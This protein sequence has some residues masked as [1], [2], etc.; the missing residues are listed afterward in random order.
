MSDSMGTSD[1]EN[2]M[3]ALVFQCAGCKLIVGDSYCMHSTNEAMKSI[4]LTA[5]SNIRR[6]HDIYTSK[7]GLDVGS[8]YF[9]FTCSGCDGALGNYY[10]TTSKELDDIRERFTFFI[11]KVTSYELGKAEHGKMP[12]PQD[13]QRGGGGGGGDGAG[14]AGDADSASVEALR[15]EILKIQHV[16]LDH[17]V[18]LSVVEQTVASKKRMRE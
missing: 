7:T 3:N 8:T 10:L 14:V 12:D 13:T 1:A 4:T 6:S 2:E 5:A 11:D 17:G 18:R 16:L 15:E 9:S